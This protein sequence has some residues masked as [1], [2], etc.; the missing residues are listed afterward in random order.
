VIAS[1]EERIVST[2]ALAAEQPYGG[3]SDVGSSDRAARIE[4][5]S[6]HPPD[7]SSDRCARS[8]AV[9]ARSPLS[10]RDPAPKAAR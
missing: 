7:R 4:P 5:A 2:S 6:P 10:L 8:H 9:R 1:M 3:I